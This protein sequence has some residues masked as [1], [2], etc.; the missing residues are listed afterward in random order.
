MLEKCQDRVI[1]R[2]NPDQDHCIRRVSLTELCEYLQRLSSCIQFQT[3]SIIYANGQRIIRKLVNA[4]LEA[5]RC[6]HCV[7][8]F[9]PSCIVQC[10]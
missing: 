7:D 4:I 3:Y 6:R 5:Q 8:G 10:L 2:F 1:L 9:T